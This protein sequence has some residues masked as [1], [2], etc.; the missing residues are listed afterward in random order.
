MKWMG[1]VTVAVAMACD[2]AQV[3]TPPVPPLATVFT[4]TGTITAKVDEFRNALGQQV[5]G[6]RY[7]PGKWSLKEVLGHITDDERIFAFR[8]LCLARGET[9]PPA[10][11]DEKVYAS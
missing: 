5:R 10:G 7:A 2:D 3:T 4:A 8:A 11:F 9:Q 6:L 1:L